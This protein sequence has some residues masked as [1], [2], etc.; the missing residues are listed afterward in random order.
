MAC[1]KYISNLHPHNIEDTRRYRRDSHPRG[2]LRASKRTWILKTSET[3]TP[4]RERTLY[5]S[6]A[7]NK[8]SQLTCPQV[9]K[10]RIRRLRA[11]LRITTLLLAIYMTVSMIITLNKYLSSRHVIRGGRNAW[12]KQSTT[13]PTIPLLATSS[14]TL[15]INAA[16]VVAYLKSIRAANRTHDYASWIGGGVFVAHMGMWI[17]TAVLYRTGKTGHDL[18]GWSCDPK[19]KKIQPQFSDVVKFERYCNL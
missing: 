19:A 17:A 4:L 10:A 11:V 8:R 16:V 15:Q 1:Q 5:V 12:A 3:G 6:D 2:S 14:I 13:W 7:C 9:M 18:W